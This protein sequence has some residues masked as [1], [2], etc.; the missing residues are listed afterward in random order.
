[1]NPNHQELIRDRAYALW[2]ADGMPDGKDKE[3]WA[4][5]E[6]ELSDESEL[7]LSEEDSEIRPAPLIAGL[8]IL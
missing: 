7:D 1:M 5:A 2:E 6:R 8:P 4:K 3:Y